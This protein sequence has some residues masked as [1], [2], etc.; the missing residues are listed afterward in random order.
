[1]PH[2]TDPAALEE[3]RIKV[4]RAYTAWQQY[5]RFSQAQVDAVVEQIA[6][7]GREHARRLAEMAVAETTYG[8]VEDK[9][10]KNFLC[11]EWLPKRIRGMR[12][13]GLLREIPEEKIAEYGVPMGVVAAIVPTTNPTSTVIYKVIVSLKA[14]NGIVISPHPSAKGCTYE[15]A[16]ICHRA[17][18]KAG[19]PEGIIQCLSRPTLEGTQALMKHERVAVI[20]ATGG[21]GMVRAAYSSGKPA[22]G[23]GPGNVPVLL[24][25]S[26]NAGEA[27]A[28][29]IQGKAFDYGTVC[30]SEQSLVA[31]EGL[32]DAV[33]AELK[34]GKAYLCNDADREALER[35]LIRAG[36]GINPKCVGQSPAKI[37]EMA[38]IRIPADTSIL[39]VEI[40]GVGRQH[41]LSAE[42]LSPVLA[43]L[44]V[45]DFEAAL[46]ACESVLNYGGRGHTC[47]IFSKDEVRIRAFAERMPAMR[48]MVNTQSPA[49]SVGI[50]TNLLPSMTLGCGAM[51]GNST[52]D[53]IGPLHL[54]NVKRLTYAVR[55]P[56]EAFTVPPAGAAA[57]TPDA[58]EREAVRAAVERYLAERG[59]RLDA[60]LE[61]AAPAPA[62]P[63]PAVAPASTP[64]SAASV[65][66]QVVDEFLAA[67]RI[68]AAP[69]AP[70]P[71]PPP[72]PSPPPPESTPQVR[73][74]EFVC[75]NDVRE[76]LRESR[77]IYIGPKTIVTPSARELGN[78]H[79]ILIVAERSTK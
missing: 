6:A 46:E 74:A 73:I 22:L 61:A 69:A 76:A 17:A 41:P 40:K 51:G 59:I 15:T 14:G 2:E 68:S 72:V 24:D 70:A 36:G 35:T 62:S 58:G 50:T 57:R 12:T 56:E 75:E 78:Q 67:R 10:T 52:G 19:A 38:G 63:A 39:A 32:R 30:S 11:A 13:V 45:R 21:A 34:A 55:R 47:V 33:L 27:V 9:V 31:E 29:V 54:I 25:R 48:V 28:Q 18:V 65:A 4:E 1:M 79:D 16:E 26:Y 53:N 20:L 42:K 64:P 8:N 71:A 43:L 44:F 66:R 37:A 60:P 5:R 3:V 23:V 77:K 7:E 49:G